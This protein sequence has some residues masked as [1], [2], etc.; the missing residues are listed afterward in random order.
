MTIAAAVHLTSSDETRVIRRAA[1]LARSEGESCFTISIV[2][3]LPYGATQEAEWEAISHNLAI[4]EEEQAS[5]IVQ[6]ANDVPKAIVGVCQA[7][8]ISTLL[9][10]TGQ[11]VERMLDLDPPFNVVIVGSR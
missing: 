6:E 5:P 11:M 10:R 2:D 3:A 4:I 9:L 1:A 7:F 8:G